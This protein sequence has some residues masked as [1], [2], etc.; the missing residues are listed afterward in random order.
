MSA[1]IT[2]LTPMTDRACLLHALADL[3]FGPE[4]VEVHE[5]PVSLVG[6]QGDRRVQHAHVVIRRQHVGG[7]S[8]DLGFMET[9]TGYQL[10]VSDYDQRKF[11]DTWL[12]ELGERYAH[13]RRVQE[14]RAAEE[15]RRRIAEQ[16]RALVE[17]QRNAIHERAKKLG[18]RVEES[19]EGEK[20]RLV[21]V[22][23]VYG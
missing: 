17:T 18:Y 2:L 10:I 19:R 5:G 15:E 3:G 4:K 9:K 12:R 23:R 1:Y 6:Y 11:G 7:A 8:N 13:H 14:E 21:L 20:V 16:R 22:K